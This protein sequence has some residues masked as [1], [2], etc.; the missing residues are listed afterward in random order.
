MRLVSVALW[1]LLGSPLVVLSAAQESQS[2]GRPPYVRLYSGVGV[3]R[4]SSLRIRQPGLVT[5]LTFTPVS[6]EHRSLTT[7]WT[8]DSIPD[9][10]VRAGFFVSRA[11]WL[12][13]SVEVVHFKILA[14]TDESAQVSGTHR[15]VSVDTVAPVGQFVEVY[16]VTNGV[17]LFMANVELHAGKLSTSHEPRLDVGRFPFQPL[18]SGEVS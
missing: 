13:G 11:P 2:V 5:D 1:L 10:G 8:R 9:V 15:G 12:A 16:R 18:K 17:N 7:D 14:E 3:T 6:W 4:E